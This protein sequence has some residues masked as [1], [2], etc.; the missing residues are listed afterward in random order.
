L[1]R[2]RSHLRTLGI[3]IAD[4]PRRGR[5]GQR[6][7]RLSQDLGLRV[8]ETATLAAAP[9]VGLR[10]ERQHDEKRQHA[11]V[12]EGMVSPAKSRSSDGADASDAD[13]DEPQ[14]EALA[15]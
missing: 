10:E 5:Q 11:E 15:S 2:A 3:E 4:L 6:S 8:Q 1:N 13:V 14:F 9:Q 12:Y 7:F